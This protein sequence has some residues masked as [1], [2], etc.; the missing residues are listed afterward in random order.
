MKDISKEEKEYRKQR[1]TEQ[2]W[3]LSGVY[4]CFLELQYTTC[5]VSTGIYGLKGILVRVP[6]ISKSTR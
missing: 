1:S 4:R 5:G 2:R 6:P 3:F